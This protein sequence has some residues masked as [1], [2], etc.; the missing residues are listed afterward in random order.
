MAEEPGRIMALDVGDVRTGIAL[1][2]VT[3]SMATPHSVVRLPSREKTLE[4]IRRVAESTRPVLIV[5]GLP[6]EEDGAEGRQAARVRTFTE[7]LRARVDIPVEF[8]DERYSSVTALERMAEAGVRAKDRKG[9]VD[10]FA[11]ADILQTY[12]KRRAG[13]GRGE[14]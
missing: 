8:E 6:V 14:V 1:S 11:A 5:V 2:D 13:S 7:L 9:K 12:L 3:Q 10:M 4:A